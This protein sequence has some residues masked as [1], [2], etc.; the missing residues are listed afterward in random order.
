MSGRN[1]RELLRVVI[2]YKV[3]TVVG[4]SGRSGVLSVIG[5]S[6]FRVSRASNF[7]EDLQPPDRRNFPEP[8]CGHLEGSVAARQRAKPC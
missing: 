1:Y 8:G 6:P 5:S 3:S 2:L 4:T 7:L